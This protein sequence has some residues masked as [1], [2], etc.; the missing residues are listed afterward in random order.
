MLPSRAL[1]L[2]TVLFLGLLSA[3][4]AARQDNEY[5]FG[6]FTV[7]NDTQN[8]VINYQVRWGD[9]GKWVSYK[10]MPGE[11]RHHYHKLDGDRR[12]PWPYVRFNEL[13]SQE[14][15]TVQSYK[16]DK[17]ASTF[18]PTEDDGWVY[19]FRTKN[20]GAVVDLY[21]VDN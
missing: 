18:R 21:R 2:A 15:S 8:V 7:K 1:C 14:D 9:D 20:G 12:H 3:P 4:V 13:V 16:I 11:K 10:L 6:T 17:T 5:E 19:V